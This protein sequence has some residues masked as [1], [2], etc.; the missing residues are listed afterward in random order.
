LWGKSGR[1]AAPFIGPERGEAGGQV[2]TDGSSVELQDAMVLGGETTPGGETGGRGRG[3]GGT[4][5]HGASD[6]MGA[7]QGTMAVGLVAA[8]WAS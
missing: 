2:V 3:W 6:G 4:W 5:L 8:A 1:A 7:A